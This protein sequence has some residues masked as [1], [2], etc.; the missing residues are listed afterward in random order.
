MKREGDLPPRPGEQVNME[1]VGD[2]KPIVAIV[3]N[4]PAFFTV[5]EALALTSKLLISVEVLLARN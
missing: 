2:V 4:E 3:N 1:I 5:Q